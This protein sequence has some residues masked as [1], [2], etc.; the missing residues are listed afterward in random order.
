VSRWYAEGMFIRKKPNKSGSISLQIID[1]SSGYKVVKT[2][3]SAKDPKQI[4]RLEIEAGNF[5]A[6]NQQ[7]LFSFKNKEEVAVEDFLQSLSNSQIHTIGP[8]LIFGTL[9]DRI[10]FNSIQEELFRHITIARLAYPVSKLKTVDYLYR[11]RR[12]QTDP[13]EIYRFLDR[14]NEKYKETAERIAYEYTKRSLTQTSGVS[15]NKTSLY[16]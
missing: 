2:I 4:K 11:Y 1:K 13:D 3:G 12:I 7:R 15:Y 6:G 9:F 5:I 10:G 8:E 16:F 14:L